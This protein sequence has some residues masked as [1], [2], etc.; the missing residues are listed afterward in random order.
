V[1]KMAG[2]LNIRL[3]GTLGST[4]YCDIEG[5]PNPL[6]ITIPVGVTNTTDVGLYV[7]ITLVGGPAGYAN[8]TDQFGLLAA[9]SSSIYLWTIDR[10]TPA[11]AGG[12]LSEAITAEVEFFTD[13]G[14]LNSY[15]S[16]QL[17]ITI[18]WFDKGDVAWTQVDVDDFDDGTYQGWANASGRIDVS[19]AGGESTLQLVTNH[20]LST[21]YAL[22]VTNGV[23]NTSR[24]VR[25]QFDASGLGYTKARIIIHARIGSGSEKIA[26]KVGDNLILTGAV[27]DVMGNGEWIRIAFNF[28][29]DA[30]Y[31]VTFQHG[32]DYLDNMIDEIYLI[33]K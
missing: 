28:P 3:Y 10:T 5:L 27:S 6:T 7:Q 32:N 8:Y 4:F 26:L 23:T 19:F 12:E 29:V 24:V 31:Y 17:N 14:Y 11:L 25:K 22:T 15:N 13:A 33:G 2:T 30:A 1:I 18:E 21:P 16:Q 9:N 20:F